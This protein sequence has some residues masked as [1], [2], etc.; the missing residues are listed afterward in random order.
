MLKSNK[1]AVLVVTLWI[2]AILSLLAIGIGFR[3]AIEVKLLSYQIDSLKAYEIAKAGII[4]AIVELEKDDTPDKDVLWACGISL[5]PTETQEDKFRDIKV[6]EGHFEISYE[7]ENGNKIYGIEDLQGKI[8]INTAPKEVLK[9][10]HSKIT[11][12]I[13]NNIMAY[14]GEGSSGD[15]SGRE[16]TAKNASFDLKGE[17]LLVPDFTAE[18]FTG[19]AQ[20]ATQAAVTEAGIK[21]F[22][23]VYPKRQDSKDFKVNI[24]TAR[25]KTLETLLAAVGL[26]K[27]MGGK[28]VQ[29]RAGKDANIETSD[30]NNW[31]QGGSET[32]FKTF[33]ITAASVS[34]M[35]DAPETAALIKL[36]TWLTTKSDYFRIRSTASLEGRKS[37][38]HKTITCIVKRSGSAVPYT[39]EIINWFE[40]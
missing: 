10:L 39:I 16:Y 2:L 20:D 29:Y 33:I 21:D 31:C 36:C 25:Q 40:G 28:I 8:D 23:T 37:K 17:L 9:G 35:A 18:I 6:G 7:G 5:K 30:D 34:Y 11:E 3:S 13:A 14:R 27:S 22:I 26:D 19:E 38:I 32:D 1:A 15:Y 12:G 24:N 4:K